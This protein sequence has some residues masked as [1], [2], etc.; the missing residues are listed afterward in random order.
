MITALRLGHFGRFANQM[1]TIAGCI[2]IARRSGQV[3]G[4]PQWTNWEHRQHSATEDIDVYRH[5]ENPLPGIPEKMEFTDYGYFWGYEDIVLPD[6]NHSIDAHLQSEKFFEHCLPLIRETFTFTG[7]PPE[8]EFVAVHY[9]AGDYGEGGSALHPR[10]SKEYYRAAIEKFPG[11]DFLVFS[12]DLNAARDIF[13][14]IGPKMRYAERSGYIDEFKL[15]KR[16]HSFITANSTFSLMAAILAGQPGKQIV[17]PRRWFAAST[18]HP[19]PGAGPLRSGARVWR[20]GSDEM[21]ADV[22]PRSAIVL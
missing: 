13:D 7:E 4:F 22:Y 9:R 15:M 19:S 20:I 14:D 21:A 12:D 8:N 11:R 18:V 6:G 3:Y 10:C 16:C 1:F 17:C 2:G 5:L